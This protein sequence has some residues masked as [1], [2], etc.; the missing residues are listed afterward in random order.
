MIQ[1]WD[2]DPIVPFAPSVEN[3]EDSASTPDSIFLPDEPEKMLATGRF[4]RVPWIS[5]VNSNEGATLYSA[6]N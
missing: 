5:G 2:D 1:G 3:S 4:N 6:S